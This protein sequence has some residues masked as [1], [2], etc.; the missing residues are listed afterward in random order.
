[1]LNQI[2]KMVRE[3]G[4]HL[5]DYSR[6]QRTAATF[7]RHVQW[8]DS[9]AKA[10]QRIDNYL[11][12]SDENALVRGYGKLPLVKCPIRLGCS[13]MSEWS[14]LADPSCDKSAKRCCDLLEHACTCGKISIRR[15]KHHATGI[16]YGIEMKDFKNVLIHNLKEEAMQRFVAGKLEFRLQGS[17]VFS[18]ESDESDCSPEDNDKEVKSY[19]FQL[20]ETPADFANVESLRNHSC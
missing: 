1:M 14:R 10:V 13:D 12:G 3:Q 9:F 8:N 18:D 7:S 4:A 16:G 17:M 20:N 11:G 6:G 15:H 5:H 2:K 19:K